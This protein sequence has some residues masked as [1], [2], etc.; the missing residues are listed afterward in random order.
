M[1][2]QLLNLLF[3]ASAPLVGPLIV[4]VLSIFALR[5]R[6][7]WTIATGASLFTLAAF[8]FFAF[9]SYGWSIRNLSNDGSGTPAVA[10]FMETMPSLLLISGIPFAFGL[11][12]VLTWKDIR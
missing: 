10:R 6:A 4:L 11:F 1:I 9:G 2:E 7:R 5:F 8:L 12:L 3:G